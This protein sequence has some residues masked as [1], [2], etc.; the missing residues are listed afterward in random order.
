MSVDP[1]PK[2]LSKDINRKLQEDGMPKDHRYLMKSQQEQEGDE[3]A[4]W[5][6]FETHEA[7]CGNCLHHD[8]EKGR[9]GLKDRQVKPTGICQD[10]IYVRRM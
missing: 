5:R 6:P 1:V 8:S 9:C 10:H 7:C 4:K 2:K 3:W